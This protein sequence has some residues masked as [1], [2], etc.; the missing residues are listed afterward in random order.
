MLHQLSTNSAANPRGSLSGN[1]RPGSQRGS[2]MMGTYPENMSSEL[3]RNSG[4]GG[5]AGGRSTSKNLN[6]SNSLPLVDGVPVTPATMNMGGGRVSGKSDRLSVASGKDG[7]LGPGGRARSAK[8]S[9]GGGATTLR[10]LLERGETDHDHSRAL[11]EL[12]ERD[13]GL[14]LFGGNDA[15]LGTDA[16]SMRDPVYMTAQLSNKNSEKL[17]Q[18]LIWRANQTLCMMKHWMGYRIDS[19]IQQAF[20][21]VEELR[22]A[23]RNKDHDTADEKRLL[24]KIKTDF[25]LQPY[26]DEMVMGGKEGKIAGE[27][28]DEHGSTS[29]TSPTSG[30]ASP[31]DGIIP[32]EQA[33]WSGA[34]HTSRGQRSILKSGGAGV[35]GALN[36]GGNRRTGGSVRAQVEGVAFDAAAV[37][38]HENDS[39]DDAIKEVMSMSVGLGPGGDN[40]GDTGMSMGGAQSNFK[41][42]KS[43]KSKKFKKKMKTKGTKGFKSG[44]VGTVNTIGTIGTM[45]TMGDL[46]DS[47]SGLSGD[48]DDYSDD[49]DDDDNKKSMAPGGAKG[50][51]SFKNTVTNDD[52]GI[53]TPGGQGRRRSS[54]NF[55]GDGRR[56][57]SHGGGIGNSSFDYKKKRLSWK[58]KIED[59]KTIRQHPNEHRDAASVAASEAERHRD[60]AAGRPGGVIGGRPGDN[61]SERS[62]GSLSKGVVVVDPADADSLESEFSDD[63]DDSSGFSNLDTDDDMPGAAKKQ[64][65]QKKTKSEQRRNSREKENKNEWERTSIKGDSSGDEE[66]REGQPKLVLQDQQGTTTVVKKEKSTGKSKKKIKEVNKVAPPHKDEGGAVVIS[67]GAT[68]RKRGIK[69]TIC[70]Q[71]SVP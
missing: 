18:R 45:G 33:R 66:R 16:T 3:N 28:D 30:G 50:R 12:I 10:D 40:F 7:Q 4:G 41:S 14:N 15:L 6:K 48:S 36:T 54:Q 21:E 20:L 68:A 46:S 34:S 13:A 38:G 69:D 31:T 56:R 37:I 57:S 29:V 11:K 62:M 17:R 8:G 47:S 43:S 42:G 35:G 26:R 59:T 61:R 52:L 65:S 55:G 53:A 2:M 60:I 63:L 49:D 24:A 64:P 32:A 39:E 70:N 51:L 9:V 67:Y 25:G 23:Q 1:S 22:D 44:T 5:A 58:A 19:F 27:L 71:E